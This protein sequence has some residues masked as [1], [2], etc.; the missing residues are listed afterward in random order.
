MEPDRQRCITR[1]ISSRKWKQI[2]D[3]LSLRRLRL[4]LRRLRLSLRRLRLS[5]RC[6]SRRP[7]PM[8]WLT[9][10]SNARSLQHEAAGEEVSPDCHDDDVPEHGCGHGAVQQLAEGDVDEQED[11]AVAEMTMV[12]HDIGS[13]EQVDALGLL[14]TEYSPVHHAC[15]KVFHNTSFHTVQLKCTYAY[16]ISFHVY[17]SIGND[18]GIDMNAELTAPTETKKKCS[19]GDIFCYLNFHTLMTICSCD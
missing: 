1:F 4:S 6:V 3:R 11:R 8:N 19:Q 2:A 7:K 12:P 13:I 5:L 10:G 17:P 14:N 16:I 9:Y 18:P 15:S